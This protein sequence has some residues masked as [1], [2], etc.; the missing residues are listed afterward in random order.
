MGFFITPLYKLPYS[1]NH[2]GFQKS[3]HWIT[4]PTLDLLQHI[5]PDAQWYLKN[6]NQITPL[7]WSKP[8]SASHVIQTDDQTVSL[9]KASTIRPCLSLSDLVIQQSPLLL[10]PL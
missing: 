6:I 3:A 7:S 5:H 10:T 9:H 4:C 1:T 8:S 2:I